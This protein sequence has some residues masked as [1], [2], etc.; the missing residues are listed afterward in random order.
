M[1]ELLR[2]DN[3]VKTVPAFIYDAIVNEKVDDIRSLFSANPEL[4]NA[5]T[6]MAGQTW[7]GFAAQDGKI[8][9][10]KQLV[11]L[12]ADPNIGDET[13]GSKPICS[14]CNNGHPEIAHYLIEQG[15]IIDTEL[16]VKNPLFASI[17]G[18]SS[19]CV[20]IIL[21]TGIDST[22]RYSSETMQNM[23]AVAFALMRGERECAEIIAGWNAEGDE[24]A[25][26]RALAEANSIAEFN[27][28]A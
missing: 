26:A 24:L 17:I 2:G 22:I 23:D 25:A 12:G 19:D 5:H 14:A 3:L 27:A 6:F 16:S 28:H 4:L 13:Y 8:H 18:Q 20:R 10:V 7:L 21:N 9:A 1:V 15:S 11:E